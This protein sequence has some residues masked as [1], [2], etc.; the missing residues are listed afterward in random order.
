MKER[1]REGEDRERWTWQS[2]R[3]SIRARKYMVQGVDCSAD[4]GS[5]GDEVTGFSLGHAP[6][7]CEGGCVSE[8][9]MGEVKQV[10]HQQAV[11]HWQIDY[12]LR[13]MQGGRV[14]EGGEEDIYEERPWEGW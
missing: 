9:R 2:T 12:N 11:L 7:L 10:L 14:R 13:S 1:G 4:G 8:G 6:S 3:H 5:K